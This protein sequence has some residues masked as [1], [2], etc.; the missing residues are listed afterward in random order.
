[1]LTYTNEIPSSSSRRHRPRQI[2]LDEID[3]L[4]SLLTGP[5]GKEI[6]IFGENNF[7]FDIA[8]ATVRNNSWDGISRGVN[9]F[10]EKKLRSIELCSQMGRKQCLSQTE[11]M[12]IIQN[13]LKTPAPLP[14]V[15]GKVVWYQYP[16]TEGGPQLS[17]V[18]NEMKDQQQSG[19]YLLFGVLNESKI[20]YGI[21][22]DWPF[23]SSFNK[24]TYDQSNYSFLGV[25]K[26]FVNKLV[27]HG[28]C[29]HH[30]VNYDEL[31]LCE[32]LTFVFEKK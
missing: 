27:S 25:D 11:T 13:M 29:N 1:M 14:E 28:Y 19:D 30:G 8:L 31:V 17:E 12:K 23:N 21:A 2:Q 5:Q 26:K 20:D 6:V 22:S 10:E 7:T 3:F 32:H 16:W 9:K 15:K 4:S 18:I 24:V